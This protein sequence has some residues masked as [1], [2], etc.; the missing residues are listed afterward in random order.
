M[1]KIVLGFILGFGMCLTVTVSAE[2][3]KEFILTNLKFP[4][5]LNGSEYV[6]NDLPFMNY[7]GNTY[8]PLKIT[9]EILGTRV[10]W[11]EE[12]RRVE[13]GTPVQNDKLEIIQNYK[14]QNINAIDFQGE[15]FVSFSRYLDEYTGGRQYFT[16]DA[17]KKELI[18]KHVGKSIVINDGAITGSQGFIH[19]GTTY[20]KES[21]INEILDLIK[22]ESEKLAEKEE[23]Q[24]LK[25]YFK[26]DNKTLLPG[27]TTV[28]VTSAFSSNNQSVLD[29]VAELINQLGDD[30]QLLF[31]FYAQEIQK[32]NPQY[33]LQINFFILG[34]RVHDI[35]IVQID[36]NGVIKNSNIVNK[37]DVS[38]VNLN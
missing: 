31:E 21:V 2:S 13:I 14:R 23:Y 12:H 3:A 35:G 34:D 19:Y 17:D 28:S 4:V 36:A 33:G 10:N 1:K 22:M 5:F 6:N 7:K 20:V 18:A 9:G 16:Y 26:V 15:I 30:A 29:D 11:N 32:Q 37:V 24:K 38:K 27:N 8:V 25:N